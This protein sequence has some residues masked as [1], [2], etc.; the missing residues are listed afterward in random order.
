ML[1]RLPLQWCSASGDNLIKQSR[2]IDVGCRV[3]SEDD[4]YTLRFI[5]RHEVSVS[6]LT[7]ILS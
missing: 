5:K 7:M 4:V 6:R 2:R 3:Y 1:H